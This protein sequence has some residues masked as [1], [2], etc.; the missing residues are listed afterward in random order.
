MNVGH[1]E[2]L[3]KTNTKTE[4]R[5][6]KKKKK[7]NATFWIPCYLGHHEVLKMDNTLKQKK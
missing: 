5:E 1:R 3:Q 6:L 2:V 4:K 7:N